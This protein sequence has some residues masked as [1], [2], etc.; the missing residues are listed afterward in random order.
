MLGSYE[1]CKAIMAEMF[2]PFKLQA[3]VE[4]PSAAE[5]TCDYFYKI[6]IIYRDTKLMT[7]K[8]L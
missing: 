3:I 4:I 2:S 7:I 6:A 8:Y 5:V 1:L